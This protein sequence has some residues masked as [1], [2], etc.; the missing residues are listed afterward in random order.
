M[1]YF[2]HKFYNHKSDEFNNPLF[3]LLFYIY[4]ISD[5]Q[6]VLVLRG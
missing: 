4:L 2:G 1:E 3:K 5:L 6:W